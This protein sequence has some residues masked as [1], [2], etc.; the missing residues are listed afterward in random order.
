MELRKRLLGLG[1]LL[2]LHEDTYQGAGRVSIRC[3]RTDGEE[4]DA[5]ITGYICADSLLA[6]TFGLLLR[7]AD[8]KFCNMT[9]EVVVCDRAGHRRAH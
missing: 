5:H 9:I 2:S 1:A 4:E 6:I 3:A 8:N 7:L